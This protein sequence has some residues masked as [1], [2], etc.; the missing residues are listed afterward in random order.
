M[1]YLFPLLH[2]SFLYSYILKEFLYIIVIFQFDSLCIL[3][4]ELTTFILNVIADIY[5]FKFTHLTICFIFAPFVLCSFLFSLLLF[6][7][8]EG[9][10]GL[11]VVHSFTRMIT[12]YVLDLSVLFFCPCEFYSPLYYQ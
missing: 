3:T 11:L 1:V 8:F 12:K 7:D 5:G 10:V 2:F 6:S 9:E 4:E